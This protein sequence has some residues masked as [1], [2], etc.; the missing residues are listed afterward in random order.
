LD[1]PILATDMTMT[2]DHLG[3]VVPDLALGRQLLGDSLGIDHWTVE[4]E[5]AVNDVFVQFGRCGSGMCYEAV[6][7]RS[8]RSPV[9][10]A[11]NRRINVFN[12]IAYRVTDLG[13]HAAR[14]KEVGF[15]AL[16]N[17][18]PAIAYGDRRIQFFVNTG[19]FLL[20]LIEAVDHRHAFVQAPPFSCRERGTSTARL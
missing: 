3:V 11:L 14:L 8:P 18:R 15:T 13:C 17:A 2:F 7:P 20:E 10:N 6:A 1:Q 4:F 19:M 12:H 16:D 5:D 9:R